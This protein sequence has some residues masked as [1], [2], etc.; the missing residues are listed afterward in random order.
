MTSSLPQVL[1][2]L[3]VRARGPPERR[4]SELPRLRVFRVQE[5]LRDPHE[6]G[7]APG[8]QGLLG[9]R[10][11]ASQGSVPRVAFPAPHEA[12]KLELGHRLCESAG[13]Y[14]AQRA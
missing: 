11:D 8:L 12:R 5:S 14:D 6:A 13:D 3:Q 7:P 1:K 10:P 4:H 9:R 2:S